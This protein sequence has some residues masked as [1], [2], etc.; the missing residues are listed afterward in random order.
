MLAVALVHLATGENTV[1]SGK[2][3]SGPPPPPPP[4]SSTSLGSLYRSAR[5]D[6]NA[7][8]ACSNCGPGYERDMRT[9]GRRGIVGYYSGMGPIEDDRNWYYRPE[10]FDD[11]MRGGGAGYQQ[12][13]NGGGYRQP[14][15]MMGY[16]Y[17]R[18]MQ[19]PDDRGY[20]GY[21][22]PGM[23]MN[24]GGGF[25]DP[26]SSRMGQ[27]PE[28]MRGYGYRGNGY[29]NLDPQYEYYMTQ[30]GA[31]GMSSRD[32]YYQPQGYYEDRMSYGG[33]Y[34]QKNFRPWD[35][36]YRGIS[37]FDNSGRGYYFASRPPTSS[38]PSSPSAPSPSS[39]SSSPS[40]SAH[41][42]Y[43]VQ[44]QPAAA[45]SGYGSP[46]GHE[47]AH[48]PVGGGHQGYRPDYQHHGG[49]DRPDYQPP[50]DSGTNC[51]RNRYPEQSPHHHSGHGPSGPS[52]ASGYG[53]GAGGSHG[54][55]TSSAGTWSYVSSGPTGV[56]HHASSAQVSYG[57]HSGGGGGPGQYPGGSGGASAHESS[58]GGN[59]GGSSDH[60]REPDSRH[61][62]T[63]YG[64]R[65]RPSSAIGDTSYL[66]D[67]AD[68]SDDANRV[69]TDPAHK[70]TDNDNDDDTAIRAK[71]ESN[72][73]KNAHTEPE[74]PSSTNNAGSESSAQNIDRSA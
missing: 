61:Q 22:Y 51:C 30:R 47:P 5:D 66:M 39:P 71:P 54:R 69:P 36:T 29:D 53:D 43:H 16:E 40:Y 19:R 59:R 70:P 13:Y 26:G 24:G 6:Y 58:Y 31:G 15:Y 65:P 35:Q 4:S 2:L 56:Q 50:A 34:D 62:S 37:G 11:R 44:A 7:R 27:Y 73:P 67:R 74:Q 9:Y 45:P 20:P 38:S 63:A 8:R 60:R 3:L 28:M 49:P 18:Y 46:G 17:D 33:Q 25:Y 41:A 21:G 32:R 14:A 64:G 68:G 52:A 12:P 23:G 48:R 1:S 10:V 57:E 55:P 72:A 42:S